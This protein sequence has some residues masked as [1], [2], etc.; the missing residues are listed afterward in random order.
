MI[1]AAVIQKLDPVIKHMGKM[2]N[3]AEA[4]ISDTRLAVDWLYRPERK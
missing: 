1:I 3:L 2:A 4:A